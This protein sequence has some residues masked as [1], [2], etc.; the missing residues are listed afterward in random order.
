MIKVFIIDDSLMVRNAIIKLL[1]DQ[2]DI[3]IIGE[4]ANPIDALSVF[5]KVG[6]P[7][8]F[9]LDIEMPKM[10]GL[11]FL[12]KINEQNPTPVIICSTL[13]TLGSNAAIDALRYGAVELIQ[14]PSIKVKEFF[15]EQKDDFIKAIRHAAVSKINYKKNL[16]N[17]SIENQS[18]KVDLKPSKKFI[19]IGSS[20]GGVQVIEE[21]VLQLRSNHPGIVIT[22]HMPEGF[23]N[24]FATRLNS[25]ATSKIVEAQNDQVIEDNKVIIAKGGIHMEVYEENGI[26]KIKLRDFPRVNSHKPSVNVLFKSISKIKNPQL[27]AFILTGMGDDGASGI[28]KLHQMGIETFGQNEQSCTI[29]GMPKEA[30]KLG[31]ITKELNI[32]QII[33]TI[34]NY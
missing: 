6:F 27:K 19:A 5:K 17:S 13:V 25:I 32:E 34:N 1:K 2:K 33:E 14:K 30:S 16:K 21:I 12:K 7:D 8:V 29:Y 26:Y 22:Q 28:T 3:D 31:G 9:I 18:N 23:T 24:S 15:D 4:A 20:T 11:T 10:D